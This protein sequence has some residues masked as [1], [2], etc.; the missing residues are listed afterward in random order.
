MFFRLL[1]PDRN[2]DR[3]FDNNKYVFGQKPSQ[4]TD[5]RSRIETGKRT[6]ILRL[7]N[8]S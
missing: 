8:Y 6:A 7:Y 1:S 4:T 3:I 5:E 2:K